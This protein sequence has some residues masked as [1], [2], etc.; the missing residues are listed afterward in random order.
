MPDLGPEWLTIILFGSLIVLL[1]MGLPLVFAIG[2]TATLFIILLWGPHALPILANRTYMAMDMF[3]LVA[4]PMFIFMGAMLQRCGIAEDM[5]ELMYH[6]MGGLRGG[7][8]AGTVLICT[9]FAAMVG[10]SG[11]A[12]TSMG[13]IALPS[14]LRRGY[15]KDIAIGSISAGGSLGILIPPSILMIILAL[16][17]R[18]S[19]GQMFIAGILPGLLLSSLMVAY[20]LIRC[21]IQKDM[22]PAV[23]P[24]ERLPARERV[25]L[26]GWLALPIGLIFAVMGSM[27]FGLATPSEASAIGAF[28]AIVSAAIK[29]TLNWQTFSSALFVTLR[30]S[31]MVI[32]IVFAA[33]AFTALY[34]VTGASAL[35]GGLIT[36]AG[37]PWMVII[38]M[39]LILFMLGMFFDP[40][41]IVLLTAPLFFPIVISLGFD[42]LWFAILFVINMEIAYLTP[43]FGFNLFYMKAVVP[44]GVTMWDI[45]KSAIPFVLLMMFGLILCMIF[46]GIITWLP[47]L[48]RT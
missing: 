32:W 22:G 35:I 37:D 19:I 8:A 30:L 18:Q 40:T 26:L 41:G 47:S 25:K 29:R 2:G 46:P 5:Y 10:I 14:M 7:L 44:P 1:L 15:K 11:A 33:S 27:F 20:I 4:V 3:M 43:P 48:M 39:Q 31:A 34:A 17:S 12:T 42:P 38:T 24:A 6:W 36:G 16:T 9:L 13:L 23:P 45:Y 21:R 28:G